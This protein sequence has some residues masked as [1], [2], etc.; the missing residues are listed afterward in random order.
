MSLCF[1][2][3]FSLRH[4]PLFPSNVDFFSFHPT[5]CYTCH[6]IRAIAS[7][8][9]AS[10]SR[11]SPDF[12]LILNLLRLHPSFGSPTATPPYPIPHFCIESVHLL[13][14]RR[15]HTILLLCLPRFPSMS[16]F[17]HSSHRFFPVSHPHVRNSP[18]SS[19]FRWSPAL[20]QFLISPFTLWHLLFTS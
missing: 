5:P 18:H 19:P 3:S 14:M 13:H 2:A 10:P 17:L 20:P 11:Y 12:S 9:P 4:V 15:L 16:F 7:F 6:T 1:L 8:L